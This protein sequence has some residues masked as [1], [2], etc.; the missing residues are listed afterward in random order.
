MTLAQKR[1]VDRLKLLRPCTPEALHNAR[2]NIHPK[3]YNL[4]ALNQGAFREVFDVRNK[5]TSI[6]TIIKFPYDDGS[7][8]GMALARE[9]ARDEI[10]A[11][12]HIET[13]PQC[14]ALRRYIP[15]LLYADEEAG[16]IAMPKY[17]RVPWTMRFYGFVMAFNNL[18]TDLMPQMRY[19]FDDG[20]ANF[21]RVVEKDGTENYIILDLGLIGA[22]YRRKE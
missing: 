20:N 10:K 4:R 21:G 17:Q 2:F 11:I 12:R 19:E 5:N 13:D 16:V 7:Y 8:R 1:F 6:N 14:L 3:Y 15:S 9:H 18:L 22:W